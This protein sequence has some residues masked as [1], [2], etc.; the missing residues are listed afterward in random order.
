MLTP[1]F[2]MTHLISLEKLALKTRYE[3]GGG[4]QGFPYAPSKDPM[5]GRSSQDHLPF[6][7]AVFVFVKSFKSKS[8]YCIRDYHMDP[9]SLDVKNHTIKLA[10]KLK[11]LDPFHM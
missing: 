5:T 7:V 3:D 2:E 6:C 4:F 11:L 8:N 10:Y 9:T 1:G